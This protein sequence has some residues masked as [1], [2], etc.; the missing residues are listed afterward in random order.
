MAPQP[1]TSSSSFLN[2]AVVPISTALPQQHPLDTLTADFPRRPRLRVHIKKHPSSLSSPTAAAASSSSY[3][4]SAIKPIKE[5]SDP[6][7]HRLDGMG[8]KRLTIAILRRL[9][10]VLNIDELPSVGIS[11]RKDTDSRQVLP[12]QAMQVITTMILGTSGDKDVSQTDGSQISNGDL[13]AVQRM[14]VEGLRVKNISV[15]T[16]V[17]K[18]LISGNAIPMPTQQQQRES[19]VTALIDTFTDLSNVKYELPSNVTRLF[20]RL[21]RFILNMLLATP[22]CWP[23]IQP[24]PD[25]AVL[26]HQEIK[27]PMD[28]STVEKKAWEG[29]YTTFSKFEKDILL[30]WKNAKSYHSN[31]GTIPKHADRLDALFRKIVLDLKTQIRLVKNQKPT[32]TNDFK[33]DPIERIPEETDLAPSLLS[34]LFCAN[35]TVYTISAMSP[36]EPKAK[37]RGLT[38]EKLLYLQLNGPFFQAIERMKQDPTGDHSTIPRF[39]IAKNRTFL[40]QVSAY[41]VLAIFYNTRVKRTRPK[42]YQVVTDIVITYPASPLYDIDRLNKY[43][44][45]LA[46]KAWIHLRPLRI[47]ENASFEANETVE[48]DYFRR[49]YTTAKITAISQPS[50]PYQ[51]K[52]SNSSSD[53][54]ETKLLLRKIARVVLSLPDDQEEE[55][56]TIQA[57][58]TKKKEKSSDVK[59]QHQHQHTKNTTAAKT[60]AAASSVVKKEEKAATN[61]HVKT[62]RK[63]AALPKIEDKSAAHVSPELSS[64]P[65]SSTSSMR[66]IDHEVWQRLF[67]ACKERGVDVENISEKYGFLK[68]NAPNSEGYFKQVYFLQDVVVQTFRQ[69]TMYQRITEIACLIYQETLKQYT[70]VH[71]HHRLSAHQKYSIIRQ[72]ILCIKVIHDAGLAHR[73]LSEVNFMVNRIGEKLEDGNENVCLYLIDF[74]KSVFCEPQDV[75]DWFV[76]VPRAESEYDGDVV[77]ESKEELDVWCANLPWVKGKPDHGYRM[78]RSIQTLPKTRSDTQVLQWLIHPKAEDIYS[79]GVMIWKTFTDTEPW[80]GVLDTDLQGLRY[81][82]E[83]DYRIERALQQDIKGKVS[84]ELLLKCLRTRPQDRITAAELLEWFERDQVKMALLEEWKTYS[85]ETRATRKAKSLHGY[86]PEV[87]DETKRRK[88]RKPNQSN[89]PPPTTTSSGAN[90]GKGRS[91]TSA[92]TT[93]TTKSIKITPPQRPQSPH[94]SINSSSVQSQHQQHQQEAHQS[95]PHHPVI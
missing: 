42:L 44:H 55:S 22:D 84:Q 86:E 50:P 75:R 21:Y 70:H 53:D 58:K 89:N 15:N 29:A 31:T 49:M 61:G 6:M 72:M 10:V 74:G 92:S 85:S 77:P 66:E 5:P 47:V 23:F 1:S 19:K 78:Y 73:D 76:D 9:G 13:V 20:L 38:N 69:M 3:L 26:Y 30:I 37:Q 82:A 83:D 87:E 93:T 40:E 16:I 46:P 65:A 91:S 63:Y 56:K 24:V 95:H 33:F 80:R 52:G 36:M 59:L 17:S 90:K 12:L 68:L 34:R 81:V 7:Q 64:S 28:L 60:V 45:E 62:G 14:V 2:D 43:T 79:I 11:E 54:M 35:S 67:Q 51:A 25:S 39:Y 71:S 94:P 41:G 48:R 57:V 88:K 32:A 4:P 8:I 18:R 27:T